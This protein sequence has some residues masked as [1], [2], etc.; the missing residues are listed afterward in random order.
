MFLIEDD[1]KAILYTG[2]VRAEPW[3]VNSIVRQPALIPYTHGL[4]VLE[5]VYLDTTFAVNEDPY[6]VFPTKAQGLRCLTT[7]DSITPVISRAKEGVIPEIGAGGGG[8]DLVEVYELELADFQAKTQLIE[9][10]KSQLSDD[11]GLD[12]IIHLIEDASCSPRR[13]LALNQLNL[14]SKQ[15]VIP[16]DNLTHL[17]SVLTNQENNSKAADGFP[18][19]TSR[20]PEPKPIRVA[21]ESIEESSKYLPVDVYPCVTGDERWTSGAQIRVLFG[22]LC[23]GSKFSYDADMLSFKADRSLSSPKHD[24]PQ[25]AGTP[26]EYPLAAQGLHNRDS[27]AYNG[28]PTSA[29]LQ[30]TSKAELRFIPSSTSLIKR[31]SIAHPNRQKSFQPGSFTDVRNLPTIMDHRGLASAFSGSMKHLDKRPKSSICPYIETVEDSDSIPTINRERAVVVSSTALRN[32]KE[33]IEYPS[34]H[35]KQ[36]K[37]KAM[38]WN[39][40]EDRPGE[41][42]NAFSPWTLVERERPAAIRCST[43]GAEQRDPSPNIKT[44]LLGADLICMTREASLSNLQRVKQPDCHRVRFRKEVYDQVRSDDGHAW[45]RFCR[46]LSADLGVNDDDKEL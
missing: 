26:S 34:A 27:K 1:S 24:Q 43:S 9:L 2:D 14:S 10:C 37:Y 22:H 25:D 23:S 32:C 42:G 31:Q 41:D 6:R 21:V 11:E 3:W 8:G 20:G 16:L 15:D 5:K 35:I 44:Q 39:K 19:H 33:S 4:R 28:P 13:A 38:A 17:L 12:Q 40:D 30:S 46:L 45:G 36:V 7:N 18:F 29:S